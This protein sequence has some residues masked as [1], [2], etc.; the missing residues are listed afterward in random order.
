MTVRTLRLQPQLATNCVF[1]GHARRADAVWIHDTFQT[2]CG[3]MLNGNDPHHFLL[4][5]RD[6]NG[7]PKYAKAYK[8]HAEKRAA[9]AW[10]SITGKA[11]EKT[12]VG[13]YP[14]NA[15]GKT[16][17]GALDIDS[18][19]GQC[20]RARDLAFKAFALLCRHE[21]LWIILG[22]SGRSGGW[23]VFI[24]AREFY[25]VVEWVALLREVVEKIGAHVQKG[26]IEIFPNNTR[27]VGHAIRAPGSWNPRDDTFGLIA[28][29]NA[30]QHLN[31]LALPKERNCS[32][33]TRSSPYVMEETLPSSEKSGVFRGERGEWRNEFAIT[34]PSIRHDQ[35][36]KLVG[37]I[38]H[39]VGLSVGRE[40]ARLQYVEANP[41]PVA[42]LNEHLSEFDRLWEGME[43]LWLGKL[44][45]F[46]RAKYD[47]LCTTNERDAFKIVCGWSRT[48]N[49]G[50]DFKLHA[51][52][53]ARRIPLTLAGACNTRKKFCSL[54]ILKQ[55]AAYIPHKLAARYQW[56]LSESREKTTR[57]NTMKAGQ[58]R[59]APQSKF[60]VRRPRGGE[61]GGASLY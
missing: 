29:D 28:F 22:T 56:L 48:A 41:S 10:D 37:H 57:G 25:P 40:N 50:S 18:H 39:Q 38:F 9:W 1:V 36:A 44:S 6:K 55:T 54:G 47:E 51:K 61:R 23:H 3:W 46:E 60:H 12:G 17:W 13:F 19:D 58:L 52:S 21:S 43:R 5:Y 4:A 7:A 16:R 20:D 45:A 59:V 8:A 24:F 35:L 33:G 26:V 49:I 32:L 14:N 11:T 53:L 31:A 15:D 30:T 34:A 2:I 42:T 27:G